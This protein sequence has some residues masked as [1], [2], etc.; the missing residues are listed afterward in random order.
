MNWYWI[1]LVGVLLG[2]FGAD[3]V[4]YYLQINVLDKLIDAYKWVAHLFGKKAAA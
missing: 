3:A 4:N 1:L 2:Y